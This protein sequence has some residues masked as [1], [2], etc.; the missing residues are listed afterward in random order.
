MK[1]KTF[2]DA[3]IRGAM[4]DAVEEAL[5]AKPVTVHAARCTAITCFEINGEIYTTEMAIQKILGQYS[6]WKE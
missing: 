2:V 5:R 4:T 1:N 3:L 6:W